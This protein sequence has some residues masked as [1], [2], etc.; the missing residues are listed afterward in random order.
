M[1]FGYGVWLIPPKGLFKTSHIAHAT[2]ACFMNKTDAITL[3]DEIKIKLGTK[4]KLNII[5]K[6]NIYDKK[7][8]PDEK[9]LLLAWGYDCLKPK[10]WNNFHSIC[11]NYKC[12]FSNIPH[13]SMLY[14][15]DKKD[16][17][18][19]DCHIN[20]IDVELYV[21]DITDDN[22]DKWKIIN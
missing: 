16:L 13:I 4:Y 1:G 7:T 11:N 8:Y 5:K 15:Y 14:S 3:C 12:N 2:I 20:S 9:D 17:I 21:A 18:P 22:P 6:A 10:Y 19:F